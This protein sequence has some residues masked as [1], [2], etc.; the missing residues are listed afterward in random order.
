[1]K[2]SFLVVFLTLII[3]TTCNSDDNV[4]EKI[5]E[6]ECEEDWMKIDDY[7]WNK[8]KNDQNLSQ[9]RITYSD[10]NLCMQPNNN[11]NDNFNLFSYCWKCK[12][13]KFSFT[14]KNRTIFKC[15]LSFIC[16]K[17]CP[18][19]WKYLRPKTQMEIDNNKTT[20]MLCSTQIYQE[21]K[22]C[23]LC[24]GPLRNLKNIQHCS[25]VRPIWFLKSDGVIIYFLYG[26]VFIYLI[27]F[28]YLQCWWIDKHPCS[29][30]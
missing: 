7:R 23:N 13:P 14:T 1:M 12:Q 17:N 28:T 11:E 22:L 5:C 20:N 30:K 18:N 15:P 19:G 24:L 2:L 21:M 25:S 6:K 4:E 16:L 27:P 8:F 9:S 3:W 10:S 26:I 29:I